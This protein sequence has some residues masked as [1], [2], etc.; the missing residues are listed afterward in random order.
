LRKTSPDLITAPY[1][2]FGHR[3]SVF[4][5]DL[6]KA[7]ESERELRII[8]TNL[9]ESFI[10]QMDETESN[11]VL[12]ILMMNKRKR[13]DT[14]RQKKDTSAALKEKLAVMILLREDIE[15]QENFAIDLAEK[16][17]IIQ[18]IINVAHEIQA[19]RTV[20]SLFAEGE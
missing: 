8:G 4:H 11:Q 16:K 13:R 3:S 1:S 12:K 19:L 15:A 5:P 14:K 17:E 6:L 7:S 9:L 2:V 20:I 10:I 18:Q